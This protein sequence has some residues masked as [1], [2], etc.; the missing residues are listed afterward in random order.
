MT[1]QVKL[2]NFSDFDRMLQSKNLVVT[3]LGAILGF[4]LSYFTITILAVP[5]TPF[6]LSLSIGVVLA[7]AVY[8]R[9]IGSTLFV[10]LITGIAL[11]SPFGGRVDFIEGYIL[12]IVAISV[13]IGYNA[14][15][16]KLILDWNRRYMQWAVLFAFYIIGMGFLSSGYEDRYYKF[17]IPLG[18][19]GDMFYDTGLPLLEIVA[20]LGILLM[21]LVFNQLLKGTLSLSDSS[22]KKYRIFGLLMILVGFVIS[23]LS[24]ILFSRT[25]SQS[26]MLG[27]VKNRDHLATINQFF[28]HQAT[29]QQYSVIVEPFNG[30]VAIAYSI[31]FYAIGLSYYSIGKYRGNIDGIRGGASIIFFSI[32][33]SLVIFFSIGSY[34]IQPLINP[35]GFYVSFEILPVFLSMLWAVMFYNVIFA[36]IY[37][38]IL[39]SIFKME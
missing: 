4:A 14:D 13:Y 38:K 16:L 6:G 5:Y 1:N 20:L 34:Y 36:L 15:K 10:G 19:G 33:L 9:N 37:Y 2:K 12:L 29:A 27:I 11:V 8:T 24:L 25:I 23:A 35:I 22:A 26:Q 28:S 18:I 21:W 3:L 30:Y 7:T 32:P 31:M 17:K 39:I